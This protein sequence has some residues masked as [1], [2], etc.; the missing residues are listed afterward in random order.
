M[1]ILDL[2]TT[3]IMAKHGIVSYVYL[4]RKNSVSVEYKESF[5]EVVEVPETKR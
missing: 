4:V 1:L 5:Q 2:T 3:A